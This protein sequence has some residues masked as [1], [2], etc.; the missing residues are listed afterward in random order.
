[1]DLPLLIFSNTRRDSDLRYLLETHVPDDIAVIFHRG[2]TTVLASALE[3]NRLRNTG[4]IDELLSLDATKVSIGTGKI[5]SVDILKRFLEDLGIGKFCVKRDFP[6]YLAEGLRAA[7]FEMEIAEFYVLPQRLV[8]ADW[9][10][11]EI[12]HA[13]EIAKK[14]FASVEGI[15]ANASVGIRK[16]LVFE[17]EVL[18][19]E[20][21][22]W[23]M[24]DMSYALGAMAE[25]TIVACGV[26]ACNPHNVGHG[27][28]LA[29]EFILIDFFPYLRSSGYYADISRT[30][31]KGKPSSE[32]VSMHNAVKS[33]HG[34]AISM[35]RDGVPA[36]GI[37][38]AV[39]GHLEGKGYESSKTSNPPRGMFHSLGHGFG[40]DIHE[41]PKLGIG[42][43][44]LTAGMV[45][46]VEPG[47]YYPEI[48]GIRIEDDILIGDASCEVLSQ[49]P[50]DWILE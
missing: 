43:D 44:I 33:A 8:K 32:Q 13:I 40:L 12:R 49:I 41:P 48:G 26:D 2:K 23:I 46:S 6:I 34:L 1:M 16:E 17:G 21:L 11:G 20:R 5:S 31:V 24:E 22:R 45:T 50:Y 29:N 36:N 37:M 19:S 14:V 18:T 27:P 42:D 47:L 30:F 10:V 9:E 3:I 7:G 39:L 28:L 38:A 4:K 35:V 15:L 25:D